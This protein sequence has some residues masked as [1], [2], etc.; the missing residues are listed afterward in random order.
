MAS[1]RDAVR[2]RAGRKSGASGKPPHA[3]SDRETRLTGRAILVLTVLATA[4]AYLSL[5]AAVGWPPFS[6]D[7][8]PDVRADVAQSL[9][10]A[11]GSD[12]PADEYVCLVNEGDDAVSLTG[13]ELHDREGLVN[14]LPQFRL[15]GHGRVRVHPGSGPAG[16]RTDLYG[17][18]TLPAWNNEGDTITLRDEHGAVVT[19]TSYPRQ[20]EGAGGPCGP[21]R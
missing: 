1:D 13:W 6:P 17:S 20:V 3:P 18:A 11:P 14:Q 21:A 15:A 16:S 12:A 9:I 2:Q 7:D 10:D 8:G 5:A 19:Q 4:I